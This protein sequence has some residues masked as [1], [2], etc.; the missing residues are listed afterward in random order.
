MESFSVS[1][2]VAT[3]SRPAPPYCSGMPA[4]KTELASFSHQ[5]RHEAGLFVF[6]V[7]YEGENFFHDEFFGGLADELLIVAEIGG[8]KDV[9]WAR[10][11]KE[12]AAALCRG[13]G[14]DCGCHGRAPCVQFS[15]EDSSNSSMKL[16]D[17]RNCTPQ[18]RLPQ[19]V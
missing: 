2:V 17:G 16:T 15:A 1:T 9:L 8:R 13:F 19:I 5:L 12:K 10:S 7:F 3:L 11:F 14:D 4:E 6:E 18:L